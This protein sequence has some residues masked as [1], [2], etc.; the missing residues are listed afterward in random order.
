MTMHML[1]PLLSLCVLLTLTATCAGQPTRVMPG[2]LP[3]NV[4][5]PVV[6]TITVAGAPGAVFDLVTTARWWPW[7][8][9]ATRAVGGVTE[10]PYGLGDRI[11]ERGQIGN[12]DFQVIWTV[13]EHVRPS[14]VVLRT[15]QPP[16][17]IT[18]TLQALNGATVF[19][20][21]LK[22]AVDHPAAM[23]SAATELDRLMRAQSEQAV[24]QLKKL[25]ETVLR[26]EA[27]DTP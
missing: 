11:Q 21:E 1:A 24:N 12:R 3:P 13:V 16:A 19:T 25:V 22:Y 9:P 10:R 23:P 6:N 20:R 27:I 8:H 18:Y 2:E 14:R 26:A 17:Q 4:A 15:D 5:A 7:W